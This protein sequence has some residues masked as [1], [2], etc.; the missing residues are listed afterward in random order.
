M[1]HRYLAMDMQITLADNDLPKV[2]RM[3]ELAGV[4]VRFPFL[5]D[6]LV[7]FA[8]RVPERYK[9]KGRR[10][11]WFFKHA[12]R[13]FLPKEILDKSKHGMGTPFGLWLVEHEPLRQLVRDSLHGLRA[14]G[15]LRPAFL[16]RLERLHRDEHAVYYG[17]LIWVL[18]Q[19]EQWLRCHAAVPAAARR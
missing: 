3:C 2:C 10:L 7:E 15:I 9:M 8:A 13:D 11:R 16:D 17:V 18:V 6:D 14:R 19:L 5:D 1:L 12:L 4:R